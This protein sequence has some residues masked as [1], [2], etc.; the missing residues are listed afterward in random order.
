MDD[1]GERVSPISG[2]IESVLETDPAGREMR[3]KEEFE[4]L[5]RS[6]QN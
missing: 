6:S 3:P 5:L 2:L 1:D 4:R